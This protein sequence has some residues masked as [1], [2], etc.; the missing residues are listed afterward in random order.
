MG[1]ILHPND[2]FV[3]PEPVSGTGPLAARVIGDQGPT[4][5]L[6]HGL[7]R[8]A[9]VWADVARLVQ[10]DLRLVLIEN[11]G[12][13]RSSHLKVPRT[14][15]EHGRLHLETLDALGLPE[16]YHVAGL[17]LGGMIAPAVASHGVGRFASLLM[18]SAS[19]RETG[20]W[21]LSPSCLMRMAGR[22]IKTFSMDH[23]VNM[24]ELTRP[25]VLREH[26]TIS[27]DLDRLQE[28]EGFSA[29]AGTAQ[30]FAAM[31]WKIKPHI[32]RLPANRLV[33]VGE[34]DRL[35]PKSHSAKL[36]RIT[37]SSLEI[38]PDRGHDLSLDAPEEVARLLKTL[39]LG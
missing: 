13:G 9:A 25:E 39:A 5:L 26:K 38:L 31:R 32:E 3:L 37:E 24:P 19:T 22:M 17:S 1:T 8:V 16:P 21:R 15:E 6:I 2:P 12:I 36:A 11:P 30:L 33:A 23:R 7:G 29:K 28:E 18:L 10:S 27:Q 34:Q 20:F 14:V 4:V 35:V